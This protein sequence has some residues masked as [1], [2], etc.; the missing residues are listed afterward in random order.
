M[1]ETIIT[2][3]MKRREIIIWLICFIAAFIFNLVGIIIFETSALELLTQ[4]HIVLL[5]SL[6]LY[7]VAGLFRLIYYFL[8]LLWTNKQ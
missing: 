2:P 6:V 5:I 1:K 3:A 7:A 8:S 4:L